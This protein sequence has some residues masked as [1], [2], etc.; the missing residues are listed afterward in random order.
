MAARGLEQFAGVMSSNDIDLEI[1]PSLAETHLA[2]LH[3][4]MGARIKILQAARA[5]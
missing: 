1:L 5:M 4:P 2:D 3:I